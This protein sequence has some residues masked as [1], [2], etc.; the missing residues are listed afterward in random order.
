MCSTAQDMANFMIAQ[1]QGGRFENNQILQPET[2][3]LMHT[4]LFTNDERLDGFAYG[5]MEETVNGI[6]CPVAWR[7]Y[8]KL[9][10]H[11]G[12]HSG[13]KPGVLR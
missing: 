7:G 1:L 2:V 3:A 10:F 9:A 12:D 5:F 11:P 8:W 6:A 4:Q 13:R